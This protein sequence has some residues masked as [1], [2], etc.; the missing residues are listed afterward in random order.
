[1]ETKCEYKENQPE[2]EEA[3][4]GKSPR[5]PKQLRR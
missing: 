4:G 2:Y 5:G 1:M 3:P